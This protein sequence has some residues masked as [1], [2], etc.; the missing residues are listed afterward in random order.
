M[1]PSI[2]SLGHGILLEQ[3]KCIMHTHIFIY[4]KNLFH[5]RSRTKIFV[6]WL[7]MVKNRK[8]EKIVGWSHDIYLINHY[9]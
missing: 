1:L 9:N 4:T 3:V 8:W 7:Y 5:H 2:S 6:K